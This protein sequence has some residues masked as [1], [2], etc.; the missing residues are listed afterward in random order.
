MQDEPLNV[1]IKW[2]DFEELNV[3]SSKDVL[4]E[5]GSIWKH[6]KRIDMFWDGIYFYGIIVDMEIM[7][8]DD[9]ED[10]PLARLIEKRSDDEND[11]V[12]LCRLLQNQ[13]STARPP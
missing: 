11:D 4:L 10:M 8:D 6:G 5:E 1:L 9:D 2:D 13:L 12:P 3:V 7:S